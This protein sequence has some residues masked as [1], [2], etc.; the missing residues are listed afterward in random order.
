MPEAGVLA[1]TPSWWELNAEHG[2]AGVLRDPSRIERRKTARRDRYSLRRFGCVYEEYRARRDGAYR[3]RMAQAE[4]DIAERVAILKRS[5]A[6]KEMRTMG[7]GN[8]LRAWQDVALAPDGVVCRR[9]QEDF[10]R[11]RASIETK[12][13]GGPSPQQ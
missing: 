8:I 7:C 11:A 4:A 1:E 5:A 3:R 12:R 9:A 6:V 13:G 2:R 10:G